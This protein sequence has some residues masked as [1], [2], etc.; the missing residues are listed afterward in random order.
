[1]TAAH[2]QPTPATGPPASP[3]TE[4]ISTREAQA[5]Q[6]MKDG[7]L[8]LKAERYDQ[9]LEAFEQARRLRMAESTSHSGLAVTE[10]RIAETLLRQ[11]KFTMALQSAQRALTRDEAA[12]GMRDPQVAIDLLLLARIQTELGLYDEALLAR[13]RALSIRTE[14]LGANHQAV[15][16]AM[17]ILSWHLQD[18]GRY[19][20][21]LPLANSSL[22]IREARF[23]A[24]HSKVADS[25]NTIAGIF[26]LLG[27]H[28]QALTIYERVAAIREMQTGPQS[29]ATSSALNNLAGALDD[30][31]EPDRAIAMYRRS[32]QIT[33]NT[34]LPNKTELASRLNNL[35]YSLRE[36][37]QAAEALT[38]F[39]RSLKIRESIYGPNH[40][41]VAR[42]LRHIG[43][44][45]LSMN[46]V[47]EAGVYLQRAMRILALQEQANPALTASAQQSLA[48]YFNR[49]K[50][51]HLAILYGKQ[52][53]N[54][55]QSMRRGLSTLDEESQRSFLNRNA[56][57]YQKVAGW[58]ID[59]GRLAEAQ[60]ILSILKEAEYHD[61]IRRDASADS[62]TTQAVLS[63]AEKHWGDQF[64]KLGAELFK[65]AEQQRLLKR[66]QGNGETLSPAEEQ[67]LTE[68]ERKMDIADRGFSFAMDALRKDFLTLDSNAR[69]QQERR[70]LDESLRGVVADL[71][72][73]VAL[74][75]TITMPD[76][77]RLLL[78][79][80]EARKAYRVNI[81]TTELNS[82]IQTL[83]TALKNP[84][85]DPRPAGAAIYQLLIEPIEAD[86]KSAN[87]RHLMV[88]LDGA[89]RYIPMAVLYDGKQYLAE[90][91]ALSL[92]I[93]A[94][95]DR[96]K[97][98]PRASWSVAGLGVSQAH[99]VGEIAFSALN[100]VP[101]ELASI[102]KTVT[103]PDGALQ[104]SAYLDAQFSA[105]SFRSALS[106]GPAVVHIASHFKFTPGTEQDSFLLLGDGKALSLFEL[107]TGRYDLQR[108]D[109]LTLSAC[110]T[111]VDSSGQGNE[112]EGLAV[113]AQRK[114]AKS[115]IAS[116]WPVEDQSTSL[117]M[118][119]FY[120]L[121]EQK[122]NKGEALRQ[123]QLEFITG[124]ANL[125]GSDT[126][127]S[128]ERSAKRKTADD[129]LPQF[130]PETGRPFSHPYFWAPFVLMGNWL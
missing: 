24:S 3:S 73:G 83:L 70:T 115:V 53:I 126:L 60:Q 82:K 118:K 54:T 55:L 28:E 52:A 40:P 8:N 106:R 87:T 127:A 116:L 7:T 39:Q 114:G 86:L 124:K 125:A 78:T 37:G 85:I 95:R 30:L 68:L 14:R 67:A 15:A 91:F 38:H 6:W 66:K 12:L 81:K 109:L 74:L 121:R 29:A 93:D 34:L 117:L 32:L 79:H 101:H 99:T 1:M 42:S 90:R 113:T 120:Q 50:L 62:R 75:H 44:T 88:S 27:K 43:A 89:I 19:G 36:T 129:S 26:T 76:H 35:G 51:P 47:Q 130:T 104:G 122:L 107:R 25:L 46:Q 102:V 57:Q 41:D 80:A 110:E 112:I 17:D 64:H 123:A 100:A 56:G 13:R 11:M 4:S 65:L 18:M 84:R 16:D 33:E 105:E 97:D 22:E 45:F 58:L 96:M 128:T 49:T 21:A 10:Y 103:S 9:A 69:S 23:G 48:E 20:E 72:D 63:D 92:Y 119:R 2:A 61:Y 108:V 71:G 31:K 94:S 59:S 111:A 77:I 5:R 98:K